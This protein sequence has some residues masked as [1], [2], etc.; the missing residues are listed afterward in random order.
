MV[1]SSSARNTTRV[2]STNSCTE[3]LL[4]RNTA[5]AVMNATVRPEQLRSCSMQRAAV[6]GLPRISSSPD[7]LNPGRDLIGADDPGIGVL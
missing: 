5:T 6:P 4:C 3:W 2:V 7:P 1:G